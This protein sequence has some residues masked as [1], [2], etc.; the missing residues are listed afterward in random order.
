MLDTKETVTVNGEVYPIHFGM[1]AMAQIMRALKKKT[2]EDMYSDEVLA[3]LEGQVQVVTSGLIYGAKKYNRNI[4]NVKSPKREDFTTDDVLEI[5]DNAGDQ[6][7][8]VTD[9]F[10]DSV[11][12]Q[13]AQKIGAEPKKFKAEFLKQVN[14]AMDIAHP[15]RLQSTESNK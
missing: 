4:S 15:V 12:T 11:L 2:L 7:K 10:L 6:F 3:H 8:E 13:H 1:A 5:F 14:K 9:A